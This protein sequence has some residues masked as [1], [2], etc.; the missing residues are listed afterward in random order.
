MVQFH[1]GVSFEKA[2]TLVENMGGESLNKIK[3][4]NSLTISIPENK[5]DDLSNIDE[6][7][8]IETI[9]S[10]AEDKLANSRKVINVDYNLN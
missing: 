1:M 5:I 7:K 3:S 2:E 10:P 4:I 9:S 6:V 8:R